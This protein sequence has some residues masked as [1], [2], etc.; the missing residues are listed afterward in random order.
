[1]KKV[2]LAVLLL[3]TILFSKELIIGIVPQQSPVKIFKKWNKFI[4]IL[5]Q[6]SGYTIKMQIEKSIPEF[7]K[8]LYSGVYDLAY[9]NPYHYVLAK[10]RADYQLVVRD[11][12]VLTGILVAKKDS[13]I[14][15]IKD[16][17]DKN[18][19]FPAP[20]AF[21][22]TILTKSDLMKYA[23][24]DVTKADKL[25]YVNSHDSVYKGVLRDLGNGGGGVM[26]TFRAVGNTQDNL[27]VIHK[28]TSTPSHPI[29][30]HPKNRDLLETIQKSFQS[31]SKE[32]LKTSI[33]KG[34]TVPKDSDYDVVREIVTSLGMDVK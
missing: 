25:R 32:E 12:K 28:T 26:R 18:I 14:N 13:N 21:A 10:S 7:E 23:Q 33:F 22:A 8:N 11:P 1:M 15:S 4:N 30:L 5:S 9:A 34:I 20:N 24:Y 6:K 3:N 19:L 31:L 17:K 29:I 2:V 16:L 27:K